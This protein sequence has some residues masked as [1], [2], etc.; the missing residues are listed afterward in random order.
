[1]KSYPYREGTHIDTTDTVS[2]KILLRI[3]LDFNCNNYPAA[4]E[5]AL[6]LKEQLGKQ[7]K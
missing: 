5:L 1:M 2:Q 7:L 3:L 6:E 4:H